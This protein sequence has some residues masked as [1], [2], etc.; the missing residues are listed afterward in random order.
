M[1]TNV[2]DKYAPIKY[3][4]I[5][6]DDKF[7]EPWLTVQITKYNQKARKLCM[8][9]KK[10]G[11]EIDHIAYKTYRN[12]LNK[13]KAFEK[14][15]HYRTLFDKIGR[16]SKVLWNVINNILK[17]S[18]N[19]HEITELLCANGKIVEQYEICEELNRHFASVGQRVQNSIMPVKEGNPI[20][21]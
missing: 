17:Q 7:R 9:A 18:N 14:R 15:Q 11:L 21:M 20:K 10:S 3:I 5:R 1:I 12:T 16:N 6:Q 13:I 4:Q 2:L 8:K 19:K